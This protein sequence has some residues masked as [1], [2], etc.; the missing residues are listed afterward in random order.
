ML[1]SFFIYVISSTEWKF[2][3]VL[4][5]FFSKGSIFYQVV[6]NFEIINFHAAFLLKISQCGRT[7]MNEWLIM[8]G[9][10]WFQTIEESTLIMRKSFHSNMSSSKKQLET[11]I[12]TKWVLSSMSSSV[13]LWV[14]RSKKELGILITRIRFFTTTLI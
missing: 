10:N 5:E 4:F 14:V 12:T 7:T 11:L 1:L 8:I 13:H 9:L 2:V 3:I 6:L